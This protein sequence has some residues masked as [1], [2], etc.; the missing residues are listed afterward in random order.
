MCTVLL[1][2]QHR[3]PWLGRIPDL[4][5]ALRAAARRVLRRDDSLARQH[6]Q[7]REAADEIF[8]QQR[9]IDGEGAGER[10][11]LRE[12]PRPAGGVGLGDH[13][14]PSGAGG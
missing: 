6:D 13:F 3:A 1:A 11:D 2:G 12:E 9:A 4:D 10:Q 5:E 14:L 8:A 7:V